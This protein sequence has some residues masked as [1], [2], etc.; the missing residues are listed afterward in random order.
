MRCLIAAAVTVALTYCPN[1]ASSFFD[2][3]NKLLELCRSDVDDLMCVGEIAG[4]YDMMEEIG[5]DCAGATHATKRQM[6]DVV[7][8]FLDDH[9]DLRNKHSAAALSFGAFTMAF[10]CRL[11][12]PINP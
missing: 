8:K 10:S 2:D 6:K 11:R 5:Y 9:P 1:P 4:H 12:N 7:L 3:G